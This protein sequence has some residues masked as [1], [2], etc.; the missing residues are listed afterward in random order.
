MALSVRNIIASINTTLEGIFK[1]S[2]IYRVATLV[3]RE[4]KGQPIVDSTPVAYDDSYA[5]QM[6]HR[7]QGATITYLPGYGDT[8]NTVNTF[9][10]SAVVFN[11]EQITKLKTDEVAMII[12]SALAS[13][14]IVSVRVLPAQIILNSQQIFATE[15]RGVTYALNEYQSLMQINYSVEITYR[16]ICFNLCPEDFTNCASGV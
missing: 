2:K 16:G 12:Q 15:Y 10:V 6:Y 11:N 13:L 14:N 4:G 1:G 7:V 9:Q 3:E 8:T 5:L